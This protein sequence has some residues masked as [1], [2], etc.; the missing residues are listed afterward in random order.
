ET[1]FE[2]ADILTLHI[3]L[4]AETHHLASFSF[5]ERFAKSLTFLNLSRGK[6]VELG[7]LIQALD[8]KKVRAAALDVLENEQFTTLTTLQKENYQ[9][10]FQRN[11]VIISPHIGGWS[12]ESLDN[13]HSEIVTIVGRFN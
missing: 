4:T 10:L 11:N 5:F 9:N 12:F 13:I 8:T 7:G 6:V 3:P 2:Q 1:I